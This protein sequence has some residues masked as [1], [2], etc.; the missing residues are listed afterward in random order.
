MQATIRKTALI[1]VM[2]LL[3]AIPCASQYTRRNVSGI[4]TDKRGNSLP[5]AVVQLEDTNTLSV[6]SCIT[7]KDGLYH[8]AGLRDDIDY[9]LKAR[10]RQYWSDAKTLSKFNSSKNPEIKLVIPID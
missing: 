4:V 7:G 9:T 5:G 8:F 3:T 1:F 10:Y 6:R 2:T